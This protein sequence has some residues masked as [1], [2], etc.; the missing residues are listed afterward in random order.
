MAQSPG[1][2]RALVLGAFAAGLVLVAA[3]L[4]SLWSAW[5]APGSDHAD[6]AFVI[7]AFAAI[8]AIVM[9]ALILSIG[10]A[11]RHSKSPLRQAVREALHLLREDGDTPPAEALSS[12]ELGKQLE[13]LILR[14]H[15]ETRRLRRLLDSMVEGVVAMDSERKLLVLNP[16]GREMLLTS[17]TRT[18][19]GDAGIWL[20][21]P[22]YDAMKEALRANRVQRLEID[23]DHHP[24][25]RTLSAYVT[26]VDLE[27]QGVGVIA[28]LHN[29][30]ELKKLENLRRDFVAN[31]SHELRT[32]I[33]TVRG[34]L[35]TL[36]NDPPDDPGQFRDFVGVA[37]HHSKRLESLVEDLLVL[38]R[39]ESEGGPSVEGEVDL[40]LVAH[41]AIESVLPLAREK[42]TRI[43][44][45]FDG[46]KLP[47]VP[48]DPAQLEQVLANLLENAVKYSGPQAEVRVEARHESER[49]RV[50]VSVKDNG[51]G[52]PYQDQERIFE[53]FYRVDKARSRK[54]GGTGLGLSIVK[55]IVQG[56]GGEVWL[57][58]APGKGSTFYFSIPVQAPAEISPLQRVSVSDSTGPVL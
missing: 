32:P 43:V 10:Y 36:L 18:P 30:T 17:G 54:L 49:A 21:Q 56:H 2:N 52:I 57:E 25:P 46:V 8:V 33:A 16:A 51:I 31:A 22:L 24:K 44:N 28:V 26:P 35:E 45:L 42:G 50:V 29:V 14:K 12:D 47:A 58:S 4:V 34:Y 20:P 7:G 6:L 9:I 38:S 5:S 40:D 11:R 37:Y 23:T 3:V 27:K 53:R 15:D 19:Q 1:R 41:G 13:K 39:L 48:G 55:H